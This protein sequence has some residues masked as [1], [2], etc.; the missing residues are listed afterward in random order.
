LYE[1]DEVLPSTFVVLN[2]DMV[3]TQRFDNACAAYHG[4]AMTSNNVAITGCGSV[5]E[6]AGHLMVMS[7]NEETQLFAVKSMKFPSATARS[8]TV[9]SYGSMTTAIAT[10][11]NSNPDGYHAVVRVD[12]TKDDLTT[13]DVLEFPATAWS[14][15][16]LTGAYGTCF[17]GV[18]K[19]NP[20][21]IVAMLPDGQLYFYNSDTLAQV[22]IVDVFPEVRSTLVRSSYS[23]AEAMQV[24]VELGRTA[25]MVY[26]M[27]AK[28]ML[29]FDV[30]KT[31]V[32]AGVDVGMPAISALGDMIVAIPTASKRSECK[33]AAQD[34]D[35]SASTSNDDSS[36][37]TI[38]VLATL[39]AV[40]IV[41]LLVLAVMFVLFT[42]RM[43]NYR[44]IKP[45]ESE[46]STL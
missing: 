7:Y 4:Y 41:L 6:G 5:A 35:A 33:S 13:A 3:E 8:G 46:L 17:L 26:K 19:G 43:A 15:D 44:L 20:H 10:Y 34:T 24:K 45:A 21:H 42:R 23:C 37:T 30:G 22:A 29:R 12:P 9:W 16:A 32:S 14:E 31:S 28:V 11:G 40:V 27:D 1:T 25:V 38:V 39:L 2:S 36:D 18:M